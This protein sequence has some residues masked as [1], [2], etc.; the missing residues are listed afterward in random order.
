MWCCVVLRRV[1]CCVLL[2]G[3]TL[4]CNCLVRCVLLSCVVL[5]VVVR[6]ELCC[7]VYCVVLCVVLSCAVAS[8]V[9]HSVT[10]CIAYGATLCVVWRLM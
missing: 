4:W 5:R 9:L 10:W 7:A 6:V 8:R 1:L 3:G 2:H